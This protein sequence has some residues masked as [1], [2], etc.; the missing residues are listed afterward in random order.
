MLLI[1]PLAC[2]V[3]FSAGLAFVFLHARAP[4]RPALS[5]EVISHRLTIGGRERRYLTYVPARLRHHAPLLVVLHG[6]GQDAEA[7]RRSTG[8]A[9]E[10]LADQRGFAVAYPEAFGKNWNDGRR[11]A[12]HAARTLNIDDRGFIGGIIDKMFASQG[13]ALGKVFLFG[14]SNGGQMAFRMAQEMPERISAIATIAANL[15]TPANSIA[16]PRGEPVPV[17][18]VNGTEDP[19]N[20]YDGGAVS[21]FGFAR[22]G[23]VRSSRASADY[24]ARLDS[25]VLTQTAE[26]R[27]GSDGDPTHVVKQSWSAGSEVRVLLYTV[28]GGGHVIPQPWSAAPRV[29]G[30]KTT[31]LDATS[32]ACDFFGI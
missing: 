24:F 28:D 15:P 14:Y 11:A 27:S 5:A 7:M 31:A 19:I 16:R 17:M 13:I 25:A 3:L 10:R 2:F 8:Y 21:L 26:H 9:F 4:V 23:E 18:L 32:A 22:R 30:R 12:R 6:A 20:P 29:L 1:L